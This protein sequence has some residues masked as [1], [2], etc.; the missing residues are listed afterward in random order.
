ML[1]LAFHYRRRTL[2]SLLRFPLL[3]LR[4]IYIYIRGAQLER[5]NPLVL[6]DQMIGMISYVNG[7]LSFLKGGT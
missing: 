2:R 1:P 3:E 6:K 7:A 5:K 4:N